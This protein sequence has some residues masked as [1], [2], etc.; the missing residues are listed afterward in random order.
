MEAYILLG[1]GSAQKILQIAGVKLMKNRTLL[2]LKIKKLQS[3]A[4]M[5]F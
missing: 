4:T 1:W 5:Q 3:V 2:L